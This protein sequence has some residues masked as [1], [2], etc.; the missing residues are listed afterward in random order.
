MLGVALAGLLKQTLVVGIELLAHD[1][2]G[3]LEDLELLL[4]DRA[5]DA[6]GQARAREGLTEHDVARQAQGQT[7]RADLVLKEVVERLDEV[8]VHAL[9]ERDQV[10]MAL[11]GGR[12]AARLASARLDDV[13]VDSALSQVLDRLAVGL[14]LLGHGEE[15]FPELRTDNAALLLGLGDAS[16]KLGVAV[17]GVDVDKVDVELLGEDLLHL[18]GLALAQQA[19]VDEHAGHLLTHGTGTQGGHDGGVNTAGQGQD[20]AVVADLLAEVRRHGLGEVVHAPVGL[21]AANLKQE[22]AQQLLTIL[23]VLDLGVELRGEDLALGA[24][25]GGNRA[26]IGAGGDGKALGHLG[27]GVAVAHPHGLLHGRGVE[28]LG[29]SRTRDG[30]A[31][32]LAHL[33]VADLAT[34]RHGRNLMAVAEAQDGKAQVKDGGVDGRSVLG[35]HRCRTAGKDERGGVHLANLVGRDVAGNDLGIHVEVADATGNELT[36]LRTKVEYEDLCGSMLI[37]GFP[38]LLAGSRCPPA[39]M[40]ENNFHSVHVTS[41]SAPVIAIS[42]RQTHELRPI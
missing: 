27:H 10:V 18:L 20:H 4:V 33:G 14:E 13:G 22:V 42:A 2:V 25:H 16:Q 26:H 34:E 32:V 6:D 41:G 24:L 17:L 1:G 9:G 38:L 12:L 36:V 29:A 28:E 3:V 40:N 7:K 19:V 31:A 5:D 37:H 23:G 15:L 30:G 21:Q 11:D 8:E 35:I 39:R